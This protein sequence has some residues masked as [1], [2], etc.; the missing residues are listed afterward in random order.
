MPKRFHD[1]REARRYRAWELHELGWN[2]RRIAEALGVTEG[3]VS[4]W[5]KTVREQGVAELRSHPGRG[6]PQPKLAEGELGR[7]AEYLQRGPEAYGFLGAVWTRAR[8]REVIR[9][10]FGVTYSARHVG[11]LLHQIHWTRQKPVQR[12]DQRDAEAVAQWHDEIFPDLK[13][14]QRPKDER[15]SS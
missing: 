3:A 7:L 8:V 14:R 2:Q 15:S 12:A 4:Q 5:F 6:G 9:K 10:E 11:R 13:K 1:W